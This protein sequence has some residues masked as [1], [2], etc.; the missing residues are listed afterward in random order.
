MTHK[1]YL[2]LLFRATQFGGDRFGRKRRIPR[3]LKWNWG[4]GESPTPLEG[5]GGC[6]KCLNVYVREQGTLR[7]KQQQKTKKN[8]RLVAE[9]DWFARNI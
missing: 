2:G 7:K 5:N 3:L 1:P 9:C 6:P 8:A 4:K